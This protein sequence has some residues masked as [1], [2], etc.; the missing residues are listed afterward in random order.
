MLTETKLFFSHKIGKMKMINSI[1]CLVKGWENGH[2][3]N[4]CWKCQL[5]AVFVAGR[6]AV[7]I[8]SF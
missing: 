5:R 3:R 4:C 8:K 1:C 6:V 2:L 7:S